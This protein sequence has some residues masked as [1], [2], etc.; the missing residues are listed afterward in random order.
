MPLAPAAGFFDLI[1]AR[2]T[3]N[4]SRLKFLA[5]ASMT[6]YLDDPAFDEPH[7]GPPRSKHAPDLGQDPSPE[8][9]QARCEAIL[10]ASPR[11]FVG[12]KRWT[13]PEVEVSE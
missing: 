6:D 5:Y 4:E 8:Q 11:P 1:P 2:S 12:A 7:S 3:G 13:V 9:I 10:R